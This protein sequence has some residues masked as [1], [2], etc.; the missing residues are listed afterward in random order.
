MF[1]ALVHS[2]QYWQ[3]DVENSFVSKAQDF[4][5]W[6]IVLHSV[7]LMCLVGRGCY[8]MRMIIEG[9]IHD[10]NSST[11][12]TSPTSR[13]FC[14]T[15]LNPAYL[16]R[17]LRR[18]LWRHFCIQHFSKLKFVGSCWRWKRLVSSYLAHYLLRYVVSRVLL[19]VIAMTFL[20]LCEELCN[21]LNLH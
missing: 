20:S 16:L 2:K 19:L 14:V 9:P 11:P 21:K 17:S 10:I 7:P 6:W 15:F 18:W 3:I 13:V 4:L 12:S 5:I 8:E 1:V